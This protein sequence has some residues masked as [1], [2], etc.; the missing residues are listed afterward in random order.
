MRKL[1]L[2]LLLG[3][4]A[5]QTVLMPMP[6]QCF[7]DSLSTG[8]PL[9]GGKIYTYQAGTSV[10]QATFTDSTGVSLNANPVILDLAGCASI[11]LTSGQSYRF[12]ARNSAGAQEWVT[13]NVSG[14]ATTSSSFAQ[15]STTVTF[16]A[17]PTFT[18]TGQY[19]VFKMTLTGNVTSSS[20][21]MAGIN[22][23]SIV[24]FELSEDGTGGRTFTWPLNVVG[25]TPINTAALSVTT[26]TF[27]WDGLSAYSLEYANSKVL[28]A[29][30]INNIIH[31]DGLKYP[32][33]A[34]AVADCPNPGTVVADT[35]G[36][37]P[38]SVNLSVP[39]TC[40]VRV[41]NGAILS[42]NV[43]ITLTLNGPFSAGLYA[44]FAGAG[45]VAGLK[46]AYPEWWGNNGT[47]TSGACP[48]VSTASNALASTGGTVFLQNGLYLSGYESVGMTKNNVSILGTR[49]PQ[50]NS[51]YTAYVANS[52]TII[53]GSVNEVADNFTLKDVGIDTGS[54]YINALKA[55]VAENA[56]STTNV[57]QVVGAATTKNPIIANVSTLGFSAAAAFH[58][59][60]L[61]NVSG[62]D[63]RNIFAARNTHGFVLKG[64]HTN[65]NGVYSVGHATDCLIIKSDDYAPTHDDNLSNIRC[66]V[67]VAGDTATGISIN[68]QAAAMTNI[69]INGVTIGGVGGTGDGIG[70]TLNFASDHI[71][72]SNVD[73]IG[74]TKQSV[75]FHVQGTTVSSAFQL[76][77]LSCDNYNYLVFQT[78]FLNSST[79]SNLV[80]TNIGTGANTGMLLEGVYEMVLN[81]VMSGTFTTGVT[82]DCAT[83]I[84]MMQN[85]GYATSP[86]TQ[87]TTTNGAII[88]PGQTSVATYTPKGYFQN[89]PVTINT[90]TPVNT[91][92][93]DGQAGIFV[94][95]D[96]TN[97][98]SALVMNDAN[99]GVT[100]VSTA[101]TTAFV[102]GAPGAT[103]VQVT[104][105]AG[106]LK[107]LGGASR[108][109]AV[110]TV[111]QLAN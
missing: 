12:L 40:S 90:A 101:G 68:P 45:S 31:L 11:W 84:G 110:I 14:L 22:T 91:G 94:L 99:A 24:S 83:C 106:Q 19:Q 102:V 20:L 71:S 57:G 44:V 63:I 53:Q 25:G 85:V 56:F 79:L 47:C 97:G 43:G 8:R 93:S 36:T 48:T 89:N 3:T 111:V 107:L 58:A 72:I 74:G 34:A 60:L 49:M 5:A 55:G 108:N 7:N 18:A 54:V 75:C 21:L 13:D 6:R 65:V 82:I 73:I 23:P 28:T 52:G 69:T 67:I 42:P 104:N 9:A 81:V 30:S 10:Q 64:D 59:F 105:T 88:Y 62:G 98:G 61:E 26:E 15:A 37:W 92:L 16:S 32:T 50:W 70:L 35:P 96:S 66:D 29:S 2:L 33:L 27:F 95:R 87:I 51:T 17:T 77:N 1:S 76:N 46:T 38:V 100:I 109:N 86:A 39:S 103:Q 4:A 80:G 78:Q 41:E